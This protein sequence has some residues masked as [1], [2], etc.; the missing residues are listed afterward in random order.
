MH[1]KGRNHYKSG[2]SCFFSVV[3]DLV[4]LKNYLICTIHTCVFVC[5]FLKHVLIYSDFKTIVTVVVNF[6]FLKIDVA[7]GYTTRCAP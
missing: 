7:L 2:G 4:S 1:G 5:V 3:G 6:L